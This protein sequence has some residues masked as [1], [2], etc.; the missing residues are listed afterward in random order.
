MSD[1]P[2]EVILNFC[3]VLRLDP[4]LTKALRFWALPLQKNFGGRF[5]S[6]FIDVKAQKI[7]PNYP[8]PDVLQEYQTVRFAE[9][10]ITI[11]T[12]LPHL[13]LDDSMKSLSLGAAEEPF[14]CN[15]LVPYKPRRFPGDAPVENNFA[16]FA[17]ARATCPPWDSKLLVKST[18]APCVNPRFPIDWGPL[19]QGGSRGVSKQN[20]PVSKLQVPSTQAL[21]PGRPARC[22]EV[23]ST[24]LTT[25]DWTRS[26]TSSPTCW[27]SSRSMF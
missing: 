6:A 21:L 23:Q 17:P 13:D 9:Y 3:K 7:L 25:C 14:C 18:L 4:Q 27:T 11:N 19:R 20:P 26:L 24:M 12:H 22:R 16:T 15:K 5:L 2:A 10:I 8:K 1:N